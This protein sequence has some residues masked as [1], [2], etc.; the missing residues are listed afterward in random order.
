MKKNRVKKSLSTGS[1]SGKPLLSYQIED[2]FEMSTLV[3]VMTIIIE[4]ENE[5]ALTYTKLELKDKMNSGEYSHVFI[6][7]YWIGSKPLEH[8]IIVELV[9]EMPGYVW[10]GSVFDYHPHLINT[11]ERVRNCT[12]LLLDT[13][14]KVGGKVSYITQVLRTTNSIINL[15]RK[16]N[17][18][19]SKRKYPYG[20][21]TVLDHT[22][23]GLPITWIKKDTF[24]EMYT[25][26]VTTVHTALTKLISINYQQIENLILNPADILIVDFSVRSKE[27]LR[28][29]IPLEQGLQNKGIP[30][31]TFE[32]DNRKQFMNCTN[33]G[34]V[35]LCNSYTRKVSTYLDGVEWPM[36]VVILPHGVLLN[37]MEKREGAEKLRNYDP[38]IS[39]FR[40]MAK[41]IVISDKWENNEDFL[42]DIKNKLN[43]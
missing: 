3:E 8:E 2:F 12:K 42:Q 18:L 19:Y 25:A 9:N 26:C 41:L 13:L 38:Y 15:M 7:E 27:S 20:T 40:S 39:L 6:D 11:N 35:T 10:I 43:S 31:W 14:E 32:E 34:K 36:V 22:F 29:L 28:V 21:Q 23:E 17:H 30:F 4:E 33:G 16:Y 24:D 1:L 37:E 5:E